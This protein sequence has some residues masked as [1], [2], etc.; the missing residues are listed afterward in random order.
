MDDNEQHRFSHSLSIAARY[1]FVILIVGAIVVSFVLVMI[2]LSLYVS[3]GASQLDLSRPGID[4]SIRKQ[5]TN[6]ES[7]QGIKS[8]GPINTATLDTF[9]TLYDSQL[10]QLTTIK[11]FGGDVLSDKSLQINK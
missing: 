8:S 6:D 5:V 1:R 2:S 11:A 10:T 7:F 4:V 9:M 3:S